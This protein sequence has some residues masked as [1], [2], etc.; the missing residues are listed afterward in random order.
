MARRGRWRWH[1]HF[2]GIPKIRGLLLWFGISGHTRW[3]KAGYTCMACMWWLGC[4]TVLGGGRGEGADCKAVFGGKCGT[5]SGG[6]R[7]G[8]H[9]GVGDVVEV[10]D[11]GRAVAVAGDGANGKDGQRRGGLDEHQLRPAGAHDGGRHER[12]QVDKY[13]HELQEPLQRAG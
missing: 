8:P 9:E 2:A 1:A 10:D 11:G 4:S 6:G 13:E 3:T 5:V 7:Q 12:E